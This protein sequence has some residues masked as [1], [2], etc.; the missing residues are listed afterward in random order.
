MS[1]IAWI[2]L[3]VAA[4]ALI[5]AVVSAAFVV[6]G[7]RTK[8][9][10][11]V[12]VSRPGSEPPTLS[13]PLAK[14][15]S[16]LM[17]AKHDR[18]LLVGI[19]ARPAGPVEVAALRAETPLPTAALAVRLDGRPVDATQCGAGC[20][21]VEG[22]VLSGSPAR[23]SVRVGQSELAFE[24]PARLPPSGSALFA[25]VQKTMGALRS[26]RY[27]ERL[28]SGRGAVVSH[29]GAQAPNRLRIR[30]STGFR[31][32]IIGRRRWI[33]QGGRWERSSF[34][35]LSVSELFMWDGAAHARILGPLRPGSRLTALAAF[36]AEPFPA[37]FRLAV[38]ASGRVLEAEMIA[39][40]HFMLH[41]YGDFN[42]AIS[43][44]PPTGK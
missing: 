42:G 21:R 12:P 19:A 18:D 30:S 34:P 22:G 1:R 25:R 41:D 26:W 35:G 24:L 16:A 44:R 17:L 40:S 13:L 37:W 2:A 7:T 38:D 11:G 4:T 39:P 20:S 8:S 28:S 29:I 14:D 32:V 15:R 9:T 23:L 33:F 43:I 5:V 6:G 10:A 27:V 31:L 3:S 36:H